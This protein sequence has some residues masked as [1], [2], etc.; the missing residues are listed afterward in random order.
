MRNTDY[1]VMLQTR[2]VSNLVF[3]NCFSVLNQQDLV[4]ILELKGSSQTCT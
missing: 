1:K 2:S 3:M 4:R